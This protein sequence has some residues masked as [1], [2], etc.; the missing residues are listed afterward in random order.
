MSCLNKISEQFCIIV[1]CLFLS[2]QKLTASDGVFAVYSGDYLFNKRLGLHVDCNIRNPVYRNIGNTMLVARIGLNYTL[3]PQNNKNVYQI[4]GGYAIKRLRYTLERSFNNQNFIARFYWYNHILWQQ[5]QITSKVIPQISMIN[6]IRVEEDF[7][8][9]FLEIAPGVDTSRFS[10][11]MIRIRYMLRPEI[12]FTNRDIPV[13]PYFALQEEVFLKLFKSEGDIP[14]IEENR[15]SFNLGLNIKQST[16]IEAGYMYHSYYPFSY[17][18][19]NIHYFQ[20]Q[21]IQNLNLN[22]RK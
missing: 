22:K 5:F 7:L 10:F 9:S 16:Q 13:R 12:Y 17:Y 21:I 2:I 14:F 19:Y 8:A 15:I 3:N 4:S 6:R 11:N 18:R 1:F 20:I